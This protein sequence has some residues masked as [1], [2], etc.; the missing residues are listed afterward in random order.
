MASA[1]AQ[2]AGARRQTQREVPEARMQP[3]EGRVV[4]PRRAHGVS[5][6]ARGQGLAGS[7]AW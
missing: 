1:R 5:Y 6:G 4:P 3:G 7:R 2:A